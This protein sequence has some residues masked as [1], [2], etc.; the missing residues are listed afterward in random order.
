MED[1]TQTN[2]VQT[3]SMKRTKAPQKVEVVVEQLK[4]PIT[5]RISRSSSTKENIA[6]CLS[7]VGSQ[8][9]L[10]AKK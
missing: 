6:S 8:N 2:Q 4:P 3:A 9:V 10:K 1:N 7:S 5:T